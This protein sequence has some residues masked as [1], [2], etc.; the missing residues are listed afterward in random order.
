MI[1]SR[2]NFKSFG[3]SW[4]H[5]V[6]LGQMAVICVFTMPF[7]G[8]VQGRGG[9]EDGRDGKGAGKGEVE[10]GCLQSY[11]LYLMPPPRRF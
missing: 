10:W 8:K 4:F 9:G 11:K 6:P 7:L 1:N 5:P 3:E 2:P